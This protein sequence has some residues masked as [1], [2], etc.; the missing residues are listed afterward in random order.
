MLCVTKSGMNEELARKLGT[1][2]GAMPWGLRQS[3]AAHRIGPK[4]SGLKTQRKQS[5]MGNT[6]RQSTSSR[7]E[8]GDAVMLALL[9]RTGSRADF[10][11]EGGGLSASGIEVPGC[12]LIPE[13]NVLQ[14][15]KCRRRED[16]MP[17]CAV[18]DRGISNSGGGFL[19]GQS[20]PS[21]SAEY[22]NVRAKHCLLVDLS[23]RFIARP[24]HGWRNARFNLGPSNIWLNGFRYGPPIG[25]I[26]TGR[27]EL[28]KRQRGRSGSQEQKRREHRIPLARRVA[29]LY[30]GACAESLAQGIGVPPLTGAA[31]ADYWGTA[32]SFY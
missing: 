5:S 16:A 7:R 10:H 3:F 2:V 1:W 26:E 32:L 11:N 8:A 31:R 6:Q 12:Y 29:V 19:G 17:A 28:G 14:Q 9:L 4:R 27:R 22:A 13:L 18:G 24:L 20:E 21:R 15:K 25:I 23:R 30:S